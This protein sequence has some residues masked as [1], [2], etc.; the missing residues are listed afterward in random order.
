MRK[1]LI[2]A[3]MAATAA[4]CAEGPTVASIEG[5]RLEIS[6]PAVS[7]FIRIVYPKWQGQAVGR[8]EFV[9]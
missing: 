5:G 3:V 9:S 8:G 1:M 2:A 4:A 6:E 7:F